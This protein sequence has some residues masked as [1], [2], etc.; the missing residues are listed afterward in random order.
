M[1]CGPT[2]PRPEPEHAHAV[3][4]RSGENRSGRRIRG[5]GAFGDRSAGNGGVR[6][7]GCASGRG[8]PSPGPRST[9]RQARRRRRRA[10]GA[11]LPPR[12]GSFHP[13][14]L[15]PRRRRKGRLL[16]RAQERPPP[17]HL[18]ERR[19]APRRHQRAPRRRLGVRPRPHRWRQQRP[20]SPRGKGNEGFPP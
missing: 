16:G 8:S 10:M 2:L 11:G 5:S 9:R 19:C 6:S 12:G 7:S 15:E 20:P 1:P 3:Q 13:P 14:R 17:G 18:R 4:W